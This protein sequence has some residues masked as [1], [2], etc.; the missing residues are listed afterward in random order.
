MITSAHN[1]LIKQV[2]ALERMRKRK[3]TGYTV[4]DGI[5]TLR[6]AV[7]NGWEV[8]NVLYTPA[9]MADSDWEVIKRC[10]KAGARLDEISLSLLE[11]LSRRGGPLGV[12]AVI[13]WQEKYTL[14]T[15]P[16]SKNP[17]ILVAEAIEKPGNLGVLIR[18]ASAAGAEAVILCDP[19]TAFHEPSCIY[20]SL[21]SVFVLPCVTTTTKDCI[22]WMGSL[23]ITPVVTT[24][25]GK[26]AH[27]E[28]DFAQP[29]AIIM[30]NEH[31]GVSDDFMKNGVLV[32]IEMHGPMDS[33]N[34]SVAGALF[35]FEA[36]RQRAATDTKH[37]P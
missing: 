23:G 9:K 19:L 14:G 12:L 27:T 24:P 15:L 1:P 30:G 28:H 35:L 22:K 2:R 13:N 6:H 17:L 36:V 31:S 34:V 4:L 7:N 37:K 29:T 20:S 5:R 32:R 16:L 21:G 10:Q 8:L 25:E 26:V 18:S 33:L 3:Q 11:R